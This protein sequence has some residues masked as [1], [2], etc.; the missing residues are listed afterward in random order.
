MYETVQTVIKCYP[1]SFKVS[2]PTL[3]KM[4]G[5]QLK[6]SFMKITIGFVAGFILGLFVEAYIINLGM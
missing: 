6:E 2:A 1:Y 5:Y 3:A 4:Q